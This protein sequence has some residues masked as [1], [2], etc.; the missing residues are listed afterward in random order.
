LQ[1]FKNLK[2]EKMFFEICV[3]DVSDLCQISIVN[4]IFC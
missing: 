4:Q 3:K 1:A 2:S